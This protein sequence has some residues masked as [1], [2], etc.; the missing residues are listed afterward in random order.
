MASTIQE[1]RHINS[2]NTDNTCSRQNILILILQIRELRYKEIKQLAWVYTMSKWKARS[3][4][5]TVWFWD[6]SSSPPLREMRSLETHAWGCVFKTNE[7]R[8]LGRGR[9]MWN[10]GCQGM[11]VRVGGTLWQREEVSENELAGIKQHLSLLLCQ[12]LLWT[13]SSIWTVYT[14]SHLSQKRKCHFPE[15]NPLW[16]E[17]ERKWHQSQG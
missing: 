2:V 9:Q 7:Q 5:H 12:C 11:P 8:K 13:Q 3:G 14:I 1:S 10:F 6:P 15:W 17:E 16:H 4:T